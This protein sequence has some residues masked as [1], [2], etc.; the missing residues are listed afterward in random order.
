MISADAA[1]DA[2]DLAILSALQLDAGL[3]VA[4]I[5]ERVN[6]SPTPCWRRIK[7][8]EEV[9]AIKARVA[10]LDPALLG[11]DVAALVTVRLERADRPARQAFEAAVAA[12]DAVLECHA[13]SGDWH[14]ALRAV[15]RTPAE[16]NGLMQTALWT[17]PGIAA[18]SSS[19]VLDT[20]KSSTRLP[21]ARRAP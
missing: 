10:L 11:F 4:Q 21:L 8:L 14:Y 13:I 2:T 17:L 16:F 1:L 18:L 7:R 12:V 6:L 15:A 3:S 9:G 19:L 20:V 5:A